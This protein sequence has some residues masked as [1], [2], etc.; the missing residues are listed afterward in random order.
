MELWT[1]TQAAEHWGVTPSR[2]RTILSNR[3]IRRIAGYPT[4]EIRAVTR[5]QGARTDL[6]ATTAVDS[7]LTIAD[8]A[9]AIATTT[10]DTTRLRYFFE[11]MRGADAAGPAALRLIDTEPA[12]TGSTRFDALLGAAAEHIA[13]Q[14]GEPGPL[15]TVT[16]ERFLPDAW[17]VSDLPSGRALALVGAPASF[18]RR[19]IYLDRHDLK[20]DETPMAQPS[21][22]QPE[23]LRAFEKLADKLARRNVVGTVHVVGGAAML[24]SYG[25]RV[26]TRDVDALFG[27]DGPML[28]AIREVATDMGWPSTW[29][30]NQASTYVARNPGQGARVFDHPNLQVMTTP[31]EHLLA[32]KVLAS[33]SVRD[34]GDIEL[35]LKRLAIRSPQGVWSIVERYF[36][37]VP[38]PDRAKLLIEDLT[39]GSR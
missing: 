35:L 33:R 12:A 6:R 13:T 4:N 36:P 16:I 21:F 34:R 3:G 29:L 5:H 7:V 8:T 25:S 23:L 17:W 24:L 9:T 11:F 30:N 19:G 15:W 39:A 27:P 1:D 18:R 26:I 22:D 32:M 37:G 14:Q 2:A 10:D 20:T 38:I 31:P 28:A